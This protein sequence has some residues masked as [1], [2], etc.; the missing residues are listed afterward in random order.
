MKSIEL[1]G[2]DL[3]DA[4]HT[5]GDDPDGHLPLRRSGRALV[6]QHRCADRHVASTPTPYQIVIGEPSTPLKVQPSIYVNN[7]TNLVFN[8]TTRTRLRPR[9]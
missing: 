4:G 6:R 8:S 2:F 1:N 9:R 3:S 7:I 5:G